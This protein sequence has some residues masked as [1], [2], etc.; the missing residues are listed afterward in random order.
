MFE[1]IF[2]K[3]PTPG[4]LRHLEKNFSTLPRQ[5]LSLRIQ[6]FLKFICLQSLQDSGFIPVSESI[7]LIWHEYILQTRAYEALCQDLPGKKFVHHQTISLIE[8]TQQQADRHEVVKAMLDWI[9]R[10]RKYFGDFT[11]E[12]AHYWLIVDFLIKNY[13]LTLDQINKI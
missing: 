11:E 4:M 2:E 12:T 7:D 13:G 5:E 6:E 8:Y 3:H 10:Y 9:P 1:N